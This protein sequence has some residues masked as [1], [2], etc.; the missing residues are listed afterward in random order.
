MRLENL[1]NEILDISLTLIDQGV[2]S[3]G[4]GN[5]SAYDRELDLIAITPSAVPYSEREA[6]DICLVNRKGDLVEG[7]WKPTSEMA[8]H[9]V[10]YRERPDVNAVVH[11]HPPYAT[12]FGIIGDEPMPMV[13]NEAAMGLGG[14]VP[15]APYGRPGTEELAEITCR[16]AG[17]GTAAIMAHHG[18]VCVGK[19]LHLAAVAST[20]AEDT[21]RAIILARSMGETVR[22]LED[23]EV[24]ALRDMFLGYRPS[25]PE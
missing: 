10:F 17:Q 11:T 12:V 19:E 24:A 7:R 18:L 6:E 3:D 22:A 16:A 8:L 23:R 5:I 1:R 4:Q 14:S 20:A 21:A 9:L 2:L 15:V 25:R 13:L